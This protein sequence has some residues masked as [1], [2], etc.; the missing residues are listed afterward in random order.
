MALDKTA[1]FSL[2]QYPAMRTPTFAVASAIDSCD[3]DNYWEGA[4]GMMSTAP[5]GCLDRS[6]QL[7][8][9]SALEASEIRAHRA[10]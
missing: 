8:R 6:S 1:Y 2:L 10:E 9:C 3:L 7:R 4:G 5:G